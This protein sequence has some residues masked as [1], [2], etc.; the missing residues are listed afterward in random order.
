MITRHRLELLLLVSAVGI[1]RFAFRSHDL[2]DL[3]SVDFALAIQRFDPRVYQPHPPGYFLYIL[4]GRLIN[5]VL[6][7]AN[8]A[9][10]LLSIAASCGVIILIYTMAMDWFGPGEARFSSLIFLFSP[11]A[12]FHGI[13]ALTYSVEAFFS[14]LLGYLCWRVECGALELIVPAGVALG[15]S[16]GVRQSSLLFLGPIFLF[17]LRHVPRKRQFAGVGSVVITVA[18]WFFP[19]I[20]ASGGFS[21]YFGALESLWRLVPG[22]DTL[23]NSS[24][25][26]SIARA[27]TVALI[28]LITYGV[29]S[30]IPFFVSNSLWPEDRR[31]QI[32]TLVWIAP[33]L[34]FFTFIF[35]K[36]VNSG[37][38]LLLVAPGCLWLGYWASQWYGRSRLKRTA[39][40]ALIGL[41]AAVNIL[42][43]VASPFYNS[44][45]SVRHFEKELDAIR[46]ALPGVGSPSDTLIIGFDAHFLGYRHA[47]YYLPSYYVFEY[48]QVNLLE[49]TRIFSMSQRNTRLL[50]AL[51]AGTYSKF[52]FFPLL[53]GDDSNRKYLQKVEEQVPGKSLHTVQSGGV[54]FVTGS[55]EDLPLLFP[56]ADSG[57]KLGVYP[58]IHFGSEAVNSREHR[59]AN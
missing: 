3:D 19:M 34:F 29:A 46:T 53:T 35:F 24:P 42:V 31:R 56:Q 33:A 58:L 41:G 20:W 45:R 47:G 16:A 44:Y 52:I 43:F 54:E 25:A 59:S 28:Y 57:S 32:F 8:L 4:L 9:L 39:K 1:S 13:V 37:Y 6:H 49:G 40:L 5:F 27:F 15:I 18:L 22:Q 26:T 2:Y 10:V 11:L 36:F 23:F 30:F 21:T 51:P 12:W 50:A 7:D 14:A 17:S 48:P 55:I 38:L